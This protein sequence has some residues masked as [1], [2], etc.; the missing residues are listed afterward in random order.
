MHKLHK[1]INFLDDAN[2]T[3]YTEYQ[4]ALNKY[5]EKLDEK[6]KPHIDEWPTTENPQDKP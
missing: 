5:K 2:V 6:T 4:K 3:I 1:Y